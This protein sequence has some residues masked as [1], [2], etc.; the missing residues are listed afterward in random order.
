MLFV[1]NLFDFY[2]KS[3]FHIAICVVSLYLVSIFKLH[4]DVN[5][6]ILIC[7]FSST[8]I[9]YNF[10]FLHKKSPEKHVADLEHK[11]QVF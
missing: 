7:I 4:I 9:V 6:Y 11:V 2:I 1:K 8:I 10:T 3:S 5:Y